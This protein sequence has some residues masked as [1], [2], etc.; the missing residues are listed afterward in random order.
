V[1]PLAGDRPRPAIPKSKIQ[2]P[3]SKI[4]LVLLLA[5]SGCCHLSQSRNARP[6]QPVPARVLSAVAY[7]RL[8]PPRCTE[9]ALES[10]SCFL[11]QRIE[12]PAVAN[13]VWTNRTIALD[14]YRPAATNPRPVIV[15]L[16]I[17]GGGYPLEKMFC[18][19]FARHGLAAV[20]VR[21]DQLKNLERLDEVDSMLKQAALDA[22]QTFDWIETRPELDPSRIGVFGISMGGIR[23]AFL[24]PLDQRI[25]A[26][27]LGLAGGDLPYILSHSLEPGLVRRRNDWLR[28]H[29][30]SEHQ[31]QEQLVITCDPLAVASSVDPSKVMLVLA[32]CDTAVP[33]K[34]GLELRTKMGKPETIF[35]P[36]GHYTAL[37]FVPYIK[38]ACLRFFKEKFQSPKPKVQSPKSKAQGPKSVISGQS[39]VGLAIAHFDL[40][41]SQMT[42]DLK[43]T[44]TDAGH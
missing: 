27:V 44:I 17:I 38:P 33:T 1:A 21:R 20:L 26:A 6:T 13:H 5:S 15:V 9:A 34:K 11:V 3:K 14:Y 42:N 31:F 12:M 37:R 36:T 40:S 30:I 8:E 18:A 23:A 7:T 16:P 24:A 43:S 28:T 19:Y 22:R 2:N 25:R 39:S 10:N 29:H 41:Q 4:L 35:L 32:M